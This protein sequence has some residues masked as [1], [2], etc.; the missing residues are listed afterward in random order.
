MDKIRT[1]EAL[2]TEL[3]TMKLHIVQPFFCC[4]HN[5]KHV[6]AFDTWVML[7]NRVCTTDNHVQTVCA[8]RDWYMSKVRP[9]SF[10]D[11]CCTGKKDLFI[12]AN[13]HNL[14]IYLI[15]RMR[16]VYQVIAKR[17]SRLLSVFIENSQIASWKFC[18][19]LLRDKFIREYNY[20]H[21]QINYLFIRSFVMGGCKLKC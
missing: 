20:P 12:S 14:I 2:V 10:T 4:S 19:I 16:A 18:K 21:A 1:A 15:C 9:N 6:N 13:K 5:L 7:E 8:Y 3:V 17:Y 11:C